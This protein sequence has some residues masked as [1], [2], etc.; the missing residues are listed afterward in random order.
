MRP[1]RDVVH[2][3]EKTGPRGGEFWWL[4]LSCGHFVAKYRRGSRFSNMVG[5]IFGRITIED[6]LA[7]KRARCWS[8]PEK[9]EKG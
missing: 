2:I 7:P 5:L 3:E 9:M 6:M 1:L 4:K 8:C